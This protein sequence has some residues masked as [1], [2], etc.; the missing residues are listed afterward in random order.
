VNSAQQQIGRVGI[1]SVAQISGTL[2][3]IDFYMGN[4]A[5]SGTMQAEFYSTTGIIATS[6]SN[7][8][9]C[10]G[11]STR[12]ATSL[13][14]LQIASL[15]NNQAGVPP[16]QQHFIF[17]N[18]TQIIQGQTYIAVLLLNFTNVGL[19]SVVFSK[20]AGPG[21]SSQAYVDNAGTSTQGAL[22]VAANDADEFLCTGTAVCPSYTLSA[23]S[24]T[25]PGSPSSSPDTITIGNVPVAY[26]PGGPA[27]AINAPNVNF[28]DVPPFGSLPLIYIFGFLFAFTMGPYL[29]FAKRVRRPEYDIRIG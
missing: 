1:C 7:G 24:S 15:A 29:L 12:L 21:D 10:G 9:G 25:Q 19:S 28:P 18:N 20:N 6:P 27:V 14:L 16:S 5:A 26:A 8:S 11:A 2:T 4:N 3:S 23:S 22:N 17:A 13:T